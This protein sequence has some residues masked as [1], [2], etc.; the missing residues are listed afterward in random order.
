MTRE[1]G[2]ALL[3]S[4]SLSIVACYAHA[5]SIGMDVEDLAQMPPRVFQVGHS[6]DQLLLEIE[7]DGAMKAYAPPGRIFALPQALKEG[8]KPRLLEL[9]DDWCAQVRA[10]MRPRRT[11]RVRTSSTQA[12][13]ST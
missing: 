4:I 3:Q 6:G 8:L 5:H 9:H 13:T 11:P 12:A 7:L 1:E 2:E 10:A